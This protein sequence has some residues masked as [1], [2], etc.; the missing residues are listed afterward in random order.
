VLRRTFCDSAEIA[1]PK[2][3]YAFG[4]GALVAVRVA[5]PS[6]IE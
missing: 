5:C 4:S 3:P 2:V 1:V 6:S